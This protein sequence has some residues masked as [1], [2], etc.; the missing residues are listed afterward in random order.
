MSITL[1]FSNIKIEKI[2]FLPLN[3]Y[4]YDLVEC[5]L[6][7]HYEYCIIFLFLKSINLPPHKTFVSMKIGTIVMKL[8]VNMR[9][10]GKCRSIISCVTWRKR[11]SWLCVL[12]F[13]ISVVCVCLCVVAVSSS[14]SFSFWFAQY[15]V[16]FNCF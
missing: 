7:A 11:E 12:C 9:I 2:N 13:Y 3:F 10:F 8:I 15:S 14:S 6:L 16:C 1:F 5:N 4:N